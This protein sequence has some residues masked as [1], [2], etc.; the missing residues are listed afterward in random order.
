MT[1]TDFEALQPYFTQMKN[2]VVSNYVRFS[3]GEVGKVA[4]VYERM[5]NVKMGSKLNCSACV[6]NMLKVLYNDY[7]KFE[8][9]YN[10][11]WGKEST[12]PN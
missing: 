4:A 7:I 3:R 1:K 9:W 2:A 12:N 5:Y 8:D 10:K 11:R 6:L